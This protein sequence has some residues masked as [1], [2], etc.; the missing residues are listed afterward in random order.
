LRKGGRDNLHNSLD[1]KLNDKLNDTPGNH[2]SEQMC[3]PA[4]P[5]ADDAIL[6]A[7]I[8]E[9]IEIGIKYQGYIDRQ[10][11]EIARHDAHEAT[12]LPE[13]LDYAQVRGLSFEVRQKLEQFRPETLGQASRISG[14]TPAAISLLMVHLKRGLG[15]QHNQET[16]RGNRDVGV[17]DDAGGQDS[18]GNQHD[19]SEA[20]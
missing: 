1:N 8:Q 14:V 13:G 20:P 7:Q 12:R 2:A 19:I 3:G 17:A 10:A 11:S 9:Q 4:R 18:T 15:R 6:L 5:L 16:R